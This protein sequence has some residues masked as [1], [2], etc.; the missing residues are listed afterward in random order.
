M[1]LQLIHRNDT[2]YAAFCDVFAVVLMH[3]HLMHQQF[4]ITKVPGDKNGH[5]YVS[6]HLLSEENVLWMVRRFVPRSTRQMRLIHF[7][8][9]EANAG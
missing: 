1:N 3:R 9:L 6:D 5:V 4:T 8:L 2:K 7:L